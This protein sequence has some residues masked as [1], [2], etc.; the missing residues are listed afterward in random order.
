M[1]IGDLTSKI[2]LEA[3]VK[4][5]DGMGGF[6]T[7]WVPVATGL[8]ASIWPV[9]GDER[10][11]PVRSSGTLTHRVRIRFRKQVK[12]SWRVKFGRRYFMIV[13]EPLDIGMV[14]EWLEMPCREVV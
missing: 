5:P 11:S 12:S 13:A 8:W 4:T 14:H 2:D 6:A 7:A 10:D 9:K 1:R 3:E